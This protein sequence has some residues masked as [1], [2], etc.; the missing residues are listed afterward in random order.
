MGNIDAGDVLA[1][2]RQA[3]ASIRGTPTIEV[4]ISDE[5]APL[6]VVRIDQEDPRGDDAGIVVRTVTDTPTSISVARLVNAV[7]IRAVEN[8]IGLPEVTTGRYCLHVV[9]V[10]PPIQHETRTFQAHLPNI[11][12]R[13]PARFVFA[14]ELAIQRNG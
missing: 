13:K 7:I 11:T 4:A 5:P 3:I 6:C 9:A 12:A 8:L 2:R 14:D 1:S 10:R